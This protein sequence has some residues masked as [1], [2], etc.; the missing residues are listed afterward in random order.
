M[1]YSVA[2]LPIA[3][4]ASGHIG[5]CIKTLFCFCSA[6]GRMVFPVGFQSPFSMTEILFYM[7]ISIMAL[8]SILDY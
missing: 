5:Y 7:G 6:F 2:S 8:D 4:I 1:K 3:F